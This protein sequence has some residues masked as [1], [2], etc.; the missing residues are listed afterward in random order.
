MWHKL[1]ALP[2][3]NGNKWRIIALLE[4]NEE[5]DTHIAWDQDALVDP[6]GVAFVLRTLEQAARQAQME[7][8]SASA[9]A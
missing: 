1:T 8:A 4:R 6:T 9:A 2:G 7:L 3:N 5:G